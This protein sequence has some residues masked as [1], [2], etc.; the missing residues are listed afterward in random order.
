[1][2][3]NISL[4]F[5]IFSVWGI[6]LGVD[7]GKQIYH[8]YRRSVTA[9]KRVEYLTDYAHTLQKE[10]DKYRELSA[11]DPLT[12]IFNRAGFANRV[13]GVLSGR[14]DGSSIG[15]IVFDIDHFKKINDSFGHD[16]GDK[17]LK[18]LAGA[19][20]K[21]LRDSDTLARWG[22]EEFVVLS[23]MRSGKNLIQIGEKIRQIVQAQK[24]G[25]GGDISI[26]ISVGLTLFSANESFEK[27]FKRADKAL[28]QAKSDGRNRSV[29]A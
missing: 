9:S 27:A 4:Y 26:T 17:I 15:L 12:G 10:S 7:S 16:V 5:S 24:L 14:T 23:V 3:I 1:V 28:Y 8:F 2:G 13:E 11:V 22:G 25:L 29:V 18:D 20:S 19:V 6:I 21:I